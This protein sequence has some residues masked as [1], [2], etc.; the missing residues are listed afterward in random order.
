MPSKTSLN[1]RCF[2][3]LPFSPAFAEVRSAAKDAARA[4][5]FEPISLDEHPAPAARLERVLFAELARADCVIA[6]VTAESANIY[7]EIG[8]AFAMAKGIV[9]LAQE[10]HRPTLPLDVQNLN[11]IW[12]EP[13]KTGLAKLRQRLERHLGL[14]R[15]GA[16]RGRTLYPSPASMPFFVDWDRLDYHDIENLCRELLLQMGYRRV[17]WRKSSKDFDIVAEL[18]KKD[19]DGY[20]YNE[21]WLV[22]LGRHAPV[23][24]LMDMAAND[25]DFF[26]HSLMRSEMLDDR[27]AFGR[28]DEVSMT[29]LFILLHGPSSL[30]QA[31]ILSERI[32]RRE[33]S[34]RFPYQLRVRVWDRDYVTNLVQ[35]FPQLGYKYFSDEARSL[36]KFRKAPEELYQENV[37]LSERLAT[38][39]SEL[40][41]ERNLRNRAERD[42]V[43]KDISFSAAHKLG[44]P[45]FAIETDLEPLRKRIRE[46]RTSD[47][48]EVTDNMRSAL[49]KAKGII[50]QF[51]SLTKAQQ[52]KPLPMPLRPALEETCCMLHGSDATCSVECD[53]KIQ[54]HADPDRL[55]EVLDELATN[56]IHW[57]ENRKPV[58]R[59]LVE[60]P[61]RA[62]L[63]A[64]VD[65]TQKYALI[66][67]KDNGAGVA[68]DLKERIFEPFF[69]TYDQGTGLGLAL[70][71]RIIEGHRGFVRES[72]L[73]G[74]GADFEIYLPLVGKPKSPKSRRKPE[75]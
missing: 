62:Q 18:P 6:D 55:Q 35:Q 33:R 1:S 20:E 31:R 71:Q 46:S 29:L 44:N 22:S 42:A 54:V 10:S 13:S 30:D 17:D 21:L 19:P 73:V 11:V 48:I 43:W 14:L 61:T 49:E 74:H 36:G 23:E 24:M 60:L 63:P 5:G 66:H 15:H 12:Y 7:F 65:S 67:F 50:E 40:E 52:I 70:V 64:G 47:A 8:Q 16:R 34:R 41:S 27:R 75:K 26:I 32:K 9:L 39:V 38:T 53:P 51:K 25:P 58:I 28:D 56:A 37:Q 57:I 68:S 2:L 4:A 59:I 45:I 3:A 69:T 72:G